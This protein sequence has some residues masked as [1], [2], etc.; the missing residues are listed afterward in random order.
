[1]ARQE[2]LH[3]VEE[4]ILITRPREMVVTGQLDELSARYALCDP[5]GLLDGCVQVAAAMQYERWNA[6]GREHVANV[7]LSVHPN[8]RRGC[9][10]ARATPK[11]RGQALSE[12]RIAC[13]TWC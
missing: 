1:M 12:Y 13:G 10:R 7:D 3:F 8:Q 4:A 11:V 2:T 9:P 5:A 6:N